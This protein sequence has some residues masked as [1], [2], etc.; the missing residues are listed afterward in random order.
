ME[1]SVRSLIKRRSCRD[2]SSPLRLITLLVPDRLL[3][4]SPGC[5]ARGEDEDGDAVGEEGAV[6]VVVVMVKGEVVEVEKEEGEREVEE[7]VVVKVDLAGEQGAR[8]RGTGDIRMR[9]GREGTTRRCRGWG[10][11]AGFDEMR[12]RA[13]WATELGVCS[14]SLDRAGARHAEHTIME[15]AVH[16]ADIFTS[17]QYTV[18]SAHA[19]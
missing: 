11:E 8:I 17:K 12:G 1:V 13:G 18:L 15:L 9:P 7:E 4:P 2:T 10:R 6:V 19:F 14:G 3:D 5:A 16:H